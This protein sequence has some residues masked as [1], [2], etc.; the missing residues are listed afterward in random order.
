M[1]RIF[2]A[3]EQAG[4][5]NGSGWGG[6]IADT[7][8]RQIV[9][10]RDL[11]VQI[12]RSRDYDPLAV[13]DELSPQQ[14]IDWINRRAQPGDVALEIQSAPDLLNS[15]A[16]IFYIAHN[17]QRRIQAEQLLQAY[18]RRV[19][20]I[21]NQGAKPDTQTD[22]GRLAFCRD[23]TV[24]ALRLQVGRLTNLDEQWVIPAQPQDVALGVAEGLAGWS[25][26]MSAHAGA[27]KGSP[28]SILLNG[29]LYDDEGIVINGNAC[30]PVDL[31]DQLG[32]D[33]SAAAHLRPI[34]YHHV[35]YLRAVDLREFNIAMHW[36]KDT[37]TL[38]LRSSLLPAGQIQQIM[39]RGITSEVQLMM[40]LK[41]RNAEGLMRFAELP[42][43]Y[44]EEASIE[45]V[46]H[47][48]AFAQ[49]CVETRFLKFGGATKPEQNNFAG[50]GGIHADGTGQTF[51]DPR[52]G[53]RAHVQ[54]LKAYASTEP[55]V[56]KSVDPRFQ[57]VRRGIAP[58][59]ERLGRRWS[60][61]PQYHT[62][63]LAI[64]QQLYESAGLL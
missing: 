24:P 15:E 63:I 20:Q 9:L 35:V 31:V 48:I 12:L 57:L 29:G 6:A 2:L 18:L 49:M 28:I 25:Q 43:L 52:I 34:G 3:A 8:A 30:I 47:D 54:H 59:L 10:L 41:T 23:L 26:A 51:L 13:P 61:E 56:Q 33:F 39:G 32:I 1:G 14:A 16:S 22:W 60:A 53:V 55:L 19:P 50:L 64:V 36:D 5:A 17:D 21:A 58:T 11:I 44:R 40:F 62:K 27:P 37:H 45:G 38:N 42:R 7:S 4:Y 46:N